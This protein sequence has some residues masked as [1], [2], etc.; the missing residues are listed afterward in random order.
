MQHGLALLCVVPEAP[1]RLIRI[2]FGFPVASP[3]KLSSES[4]PN[5]YLAWWCRLVE[6]IHLEQ[7]G[8]HIDLED[9]RRV[10]DARE[11]LTRPAMPESA[12]VKHSSVVSKGGSAGS[13]T[14]HWRLMN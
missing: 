4:D 2:L 1:S 8:V 12:F 9:H 6:L 13:H 3:G 5:R 7:D 11:I 14:A 10:D